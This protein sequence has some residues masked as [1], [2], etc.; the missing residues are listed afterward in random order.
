MSDLHLEFG[1][2]FVPEMDGDA[3]TV[4]VLAGDIHVG[5][6]AFNFIAELATQFKAI[7]YI[8]GNHEF[9]NQDIEEVLNWWM[10]PN[11]LPENVH[12]LHNDFKIIDGVNFIGTTLWTDLKKGDWFEVRQARKFISDFQIIDYKGR[13]YTTEDHI[14]LYFEAKDFLVK[15][16]AE[17]VGKK[18]VITHFMPTWEVITDRFVGQPLNGFFAGNMDFLIPDVD[19]W[20]F[21]H[22]HDNVDKML[23]DTRLVCNPRG[24]AG[25]E[26]NPYFN[27]EL[28]IEI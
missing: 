15:T 12:F 25:H 8:A 7:I 2:F 9:Y 13:T 11:R 24:Y 10:A 14:N 27:P 20:L 17:T 6:K 23:G 19:L 4:L 18:V 1:P 5:R 16:V 26:L 3:D 21:G 28:V 22:T